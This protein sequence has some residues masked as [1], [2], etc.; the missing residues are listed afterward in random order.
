[1]VCLK[2]KTGLER[3]GKRPVL[4]P[5]LPFPRAKSNSHFNVRAFHE[6]VI[7]A[8]MITVVF[9]VTTLPQHVGSSA[10]VAQ[11]RDRSIRLLS[12]AALAEEYK[13]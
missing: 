1:V 13:S 5:N 8:V 12:F 3:I 9:V 6:A 7:P 2:E 10:S 4:L 11:L